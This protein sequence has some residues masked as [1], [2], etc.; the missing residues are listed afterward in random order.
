MKL[1]NVEGRG[2]YVAKAQV[3]AENAEEAVKAVMERV[4]GYVSEFVSVSL[5]DV[6]AKLH[7]GTWEATE[8][9]PG[10]VKL[11]WNLAV[12]VS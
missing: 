4:A 8:A 3:V 7:E 2:K 1:W 9:P 11:D 6:R 5:V 12:S 10:I